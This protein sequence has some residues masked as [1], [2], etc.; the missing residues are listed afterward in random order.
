MKRNKKKKEDLFLLLA[1]PHKKIVCPNFFCSCYN[2]IPLSLILSK[3]I[4]THFHVQCPP[5]VVL[6]L[7]LSSLILGLSWNIYLVQLVPPSGAL[8]AQ[9]VEI[10]YSFS[11]ILERKGNKFGLSSRGK[12]KIFPCKFA[13]FFFVNHH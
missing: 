7:S 12:R 4:W 9:L 5:D 2:E 6:C 1:L 10:L 11:I 13:G 8:L 3:N